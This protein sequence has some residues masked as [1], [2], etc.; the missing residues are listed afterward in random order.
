MATWWHDAHQ[1]L[2]EGRYD[3]AVVCQQTSLELYAK[4]AIEQ[5]CIRRLGEAGAKTARR[6][7][8]TLADPAPAI[9]HALTGRPI[10]EEPWWRG[11]VGPVRIRL[12][13]CTRAWASTSVV[14]D[15]DGT[16][17]DG[18]TPPVRASAGA[19]P[20]RPRRPSPSAYPFGT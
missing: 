6:V 19:H 10:A 7:R 5:I 3:L 13:A 16:R 9:L 17:Q 1:H 20:Q 15:C 12:A 2:K 4:D 18:D 14:G 11:F 8:K